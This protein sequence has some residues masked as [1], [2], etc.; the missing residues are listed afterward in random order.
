MVYPTSIAEFGKWQWNGWMSR[1]PAVLLALVKVHL[2][3][4]Q[5]TPLQQQHG[6]NIVCST[7]LPPQM[8][9]SEFICNLSFT[10][11]WSHEN[12]VNTFC[13]KWKLGKPAALSFL[14]FQFEVAPRNRIPLFRHLK[15]WRIPLLGPKRQCRHSR[16]TGC[17]FFQGV[18]N[19]VAW[20]RK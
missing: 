9:V 2:I 15:I 6:Q 18:R 14:F 12:C 11:T 1:G 8:N 4:C 3:F 16:K 7:S 20:F 17:C 19:E 13:E 10:W 5:L